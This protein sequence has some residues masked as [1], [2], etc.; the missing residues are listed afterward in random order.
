MPTEQPS[1]DSNQQS[2][3]TASEPLTG[4][5]KLLQACTN[6][7]PGHGRVGTS[8]QDQLT[9]LAASLNETDR[10]DVYGEGEYLAGFEADVAQL[11]GHDHGVFMPSGTMAQQIAL[12]I[13]SDRTS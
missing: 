10:A 6:P 11:F 3:Q 13:W 9:E 8:M 5:Q 4:Q 2:V 7:L 1:Q 12:R